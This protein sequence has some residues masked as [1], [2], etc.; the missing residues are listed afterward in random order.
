MTTTSTFLTLKANFTLTSYVGPKLDMEN[1]L[2]LYGGRLSPDGNVPLRGAHTLACFVVAKLHPSTV[3]QTR[4]A[5][6]IAMGDVI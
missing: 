2:P 6:L 3:S 4:I 5:M 1:K